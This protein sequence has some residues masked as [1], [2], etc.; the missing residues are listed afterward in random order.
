MLIVLAISK[1]VY[2]LSRF[3]NLGSGLTWSGHLI[4][5]FCP[6]FIEKQ[7][8][9]F[10]KG[11]VLITGTNG[12][13][14]TSQALSFV[15]KESGLAVVTNVSGANLINGIASALVAKLT[16]LENLPADIG[17]FEVDE[18]SLPL[19]VRKIKPKFVL[20][21]NLFRDQLDRY[22]E[23]ETIVTNW[24]STLKELPLTTT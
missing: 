14:T 11:C 19:V 13:T 18:A 3:L 23:V 1:F 5:F 12:K 22:G 21:L 6:D 8:K 24:G 17:V 10:T 16:F 20:L 4:L 15:L 9:K 2:H 7:V